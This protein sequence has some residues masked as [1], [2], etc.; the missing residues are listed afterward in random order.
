MSSFKKA[1][2][3]RPQYGLWQALANPYTAEICA[4]AGFDFLVFDAEHAPN[5]V[6]LLLA[7][8]Q[9]VAPY[10]VEPIV[11]LADS[12]RTSIKHVLDIGATTL[13]VPMIESVEE[14][15]HVV[16]S[17]RYP[18]AGKRGV[19]AGL[20]RVSRWNRIP[21]YVDV[22]ADGLCLLLQVESMAGMACIEDIAALDGV[23]GVF[24]GPADLAADMG[25]LGHPTHPEVDA[26]VVEGL[27]KVAAAGC[28]AGVMAVD[29]ELAMRY[30]GE[31]ARF[32]AVGT[33]V[34]LLAR[35][36]EELARFFSRT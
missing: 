8:L 16:A 29:R 14:A 25:H 31:G 4:G 1:L 3:S 20:A 7:Q 2:A 24:I 19:G 5:T 22:A 17:T 26:M 9:A 33:D 15:R 32:V 13:L 11:R 30:T 28:A 23:D 21:R 36:G 34:A 6:P 35:G 27:N 18:P 10:P 12:S